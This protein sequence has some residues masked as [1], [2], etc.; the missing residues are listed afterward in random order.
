MSSS[1]ILAGSTRSIKHEEVFYE[2]RWNFLETGGSAGMFMIKPN[3][4][5]Y[6]FEQVL[7]IGRASCRER[8]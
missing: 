5:E 8:V 4:Y 1:G 3:N 7:E 2:K 6:P